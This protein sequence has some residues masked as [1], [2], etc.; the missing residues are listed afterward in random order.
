MLIIKVGGRVL[1]DDLARAQ[2]NQTLTSVGPAV[3]VHG[4][5]AMASQ[6]TRQLGLEPRM[7]DGRRITGADDLRIA[8][9]VY[10]GWLNKRLV[11]EL[12]AAGRP[13]IGLSGADGDLVRARKRPIT[14][15]G[16]DF[17]FV[18]D[19]ETVNVGFLRKLIDADLLPVV[20]ALSHDGH[21][22]LLN[23]NADTIATALAQALAAA[24]VEVSFFSCL[25][26]PGVMQDVQD[27]SSL[28]PQLS[29]KHYAE[30]R[31][32]GSIHSGMIPKLDT[33]FGLLDL[34]V[35]QVRLGDVA[36]IQGGGTRLI[37]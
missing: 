5:G 29:Q 22:Q 25:D 26:L 19:V 1:E 6:L 34:G 27:P 17:G 4:G 20:C 2:L 28:M 23:T 36:A 15:A 32:T 18:G 24:G 7:V 33:G 8:T 35:Q 9:M 12:H 3:L 37:A 13:A 14:A 16:I 30:L 11:A 10:A 21:G 31:Q